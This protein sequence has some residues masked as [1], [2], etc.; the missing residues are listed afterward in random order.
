M[1]NITVTV[2]DETYRLARITAAER[3]TSVTAIV[4]EHLRNLAQGSTSPR[5]RTLR[6]IV[7]AIHAR[8]G[9]IDPAENLSRED[10]YDRHAI[11]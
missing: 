1:K 2:D 10:L 11:R 6:E 3:G 4:R 8:G 9:G 7:A 5:R